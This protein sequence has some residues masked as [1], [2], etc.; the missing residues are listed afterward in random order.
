MNSLL[1]ALEWLSKNWLI[2][3]Q[4]FSFVIIIVVASFGMDP[5]QWDI[6]AF[7][8]SII[9]GSITWFG[10]RATIRHTEELLNRERKE[11]EIDGAAGKTRILD[12]LL[13][14]VQ[15]IIEAWDRAL[16]DIAL[17]HKDSQLQYSFIKSHRKAYVISSIREIT[18]ESIKV[19]ATVYKLLSILEKKIMEDDREDQQYFNYTD[20]IF[21]GEP[22]EIL[23]EIYI[24]RLTELRDMTNDVHV[25]LTERRT[26]YLSLL[27][28]GEN[29]AA[30][31][32]I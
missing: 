25:A 1:K 32:Q 27:F 24:K 4:V 9:G 20:T 28:P 23:T 14:G 30:H 2:G 5:I 3:I 29:P 17:H 12:N 15:S 11:K 13:V 31:S 21:R 22:N 18:D 16:Q 8:G 7:I 19:D 26:H 10:V 6:L